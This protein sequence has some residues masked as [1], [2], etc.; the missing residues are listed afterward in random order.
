MNT[1]FYRTYWKDYPWL[2]V[3][4]ESLKRHA[5]GWDAKIVTVAQ[6]SWG[7]VDYEELMSDHPDVTFLQVPEVCKNDYLGQQF[8]KMNADRHAPAGNVAFVDSDCVLFEEFRPEHLIQPD[9][10]ILWLYTPYADIPPGG[11]PW[12]APTEAFMRE[13]VYHEFMRR[14]PMMISTHTLSRARELCIETHGCDLWQYFRRLEKHA[15]A[16]GF[17]PAFSE[18]NALGAVAYS[19]P[20]ERQRYEFILAGGEPSRPF[21]KQFWSWGGFEKARDEIAAMGY[22]V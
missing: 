8:T 1:I 6:S 13:P 16:E 14:H 3:S 7:R 20:T 11:V 12:Q 2:K 4:L 21:M 22:A 17:S 10:R 19:D 15:A 9:G 5:K 18:F